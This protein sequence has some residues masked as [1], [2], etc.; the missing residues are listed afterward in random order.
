MTVLYCPGLGKKLISAEGD[1]V[2]FGFGG[3]KGEEICERCGDRER[4]YVF[5]FVY[6]EFEGGG[7]GGNK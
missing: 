3:R 1:E 6:R 5:V 4:G 2:G 7:G